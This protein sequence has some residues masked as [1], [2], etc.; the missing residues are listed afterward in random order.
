[1][2][3][4]ECINGLSIFVSGGEI[5]TLLSSGG[6]FSR[7]MYIHSVIDSNCPASLGPC[8]SPLASEWK[9]CVDG[10]INLLRLSEVTWWLSRRQG[11]G[12]LMFSLLIFLFPFIMICVGRSR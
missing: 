9:L 12:V 2:A 7:E 3:A 4:C 5:S 6:M 11:Q 10:K 1:M 8:P